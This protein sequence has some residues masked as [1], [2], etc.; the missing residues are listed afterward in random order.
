[1]ISA[2][3]TA[4]RRVRR[5]ASPS[6]ITVPTFVLLEIARLD[7]SSFDAIILRESALPGES[8]PRQASSPVTG[9]P[10]RIASQ[11]GKLTKHWGAPAN[12]SQA[13]KLTKHWGAPGL[14]FETWDRTLIVFPKLV[15]G[16]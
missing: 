3:I 4:N 2:V 8:P 11:A 5:D 13:G 14:D 10:E 15:A 16:S 6:G 1:M 7:A 9:V 12:H